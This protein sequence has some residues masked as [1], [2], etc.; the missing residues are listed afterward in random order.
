MSVSVGL[1]P[2]EADIN[3]WAMFLTAIDMAKEKLIFHKN[4]PS[5]KTIWVDIV[6]RERG[7]LAFTFDKKKIF[8]FSEITQIS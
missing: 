6:G 7:A 3:P 1:Q 4:N 2:T 8:F 5:D